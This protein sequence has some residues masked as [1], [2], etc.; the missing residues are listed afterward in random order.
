MIPTDKNAVQS[1]NLESLVE[2]GPRFS[3]RLSKIFLI[4]NS[5]IYHDRF[6]LK[7]RE[8]KNE[9]NELKRKR[10]IKKNDN[11][12]KNIDN[13]RMTSDHP[14]RTLMISKVLN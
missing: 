1:A 10:K 3:F 5:M 4:N 12:K 6:A 11:I 14:E 2:I 9:I 13:Q 8:S 7:S